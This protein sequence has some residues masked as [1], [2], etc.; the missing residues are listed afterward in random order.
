VVVR[1]ILGKMPMKRRA[2]KRERPIDE[3]P[4]PGTA[5][6]CLSRDCAAGQKGKDGRRRHRD[7]PAR[8][9]T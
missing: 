2:S 6:D 1:V 5:T 9:M 8:P 7:R 3:R 4:P